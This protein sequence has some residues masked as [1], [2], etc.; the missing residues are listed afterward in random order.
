MRVIIRHL[1]QIQGYVSLA[2]DGDFCIEAI[3]PEEQQTFA[4]S[5]YYF[6]RFFQAARHQEMSPADFLEKLPTLLRGQ[7][8]ANPDLPLKTYRKPSRI[9]RMLAKQAAQLAAL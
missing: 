2:S 7:T 6:Y 8:N 9:Q 5:I 1:D 4:H 3:H